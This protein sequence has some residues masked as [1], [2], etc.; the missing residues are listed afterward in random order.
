L[1]IGIA[2]NVIWRGRGKMEDSDKEALKKGKEML[3]NIGDDKVALA[4][5]VYAGT[6]YVE[7][8]LWEGRVEKDKVQ[9]SK[10][11]EY[12]KKLIEK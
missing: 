1:A 9:L 8:L 10:G 12:L 2:Q 7:R 11:I 6:M 4:M 5:L 3:K